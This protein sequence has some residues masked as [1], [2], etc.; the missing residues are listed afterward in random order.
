MTGPPPP[1]PDTYDLELRWRAL[2]P[3]AGDRLTAERVRDW[4]GGPVLVA[5]DAAGARHL[6]VRVDHDRAV[7]LPRPVAG[8]GLAVRRLHPAGQRDAA[9]ID[10]ACP[11]P[12]W[13][14]TFCG[15]CADVIAELPDDGPAEPATLLAVLER[16]RR[17]WANDRDGLSRDEQLGL[18]GELWLLLEWL[19][20][21]TVNN[22]TAW[23]GPLRGRHDFVTEAISVE[24]KTT[25]TATGPVVHR[26]ARLDQLD[27]PGAGQLYLLSLRAVPDPLGSD[28][29]DT[30]L[31]RSR[32]AAAAA[33]PTCTAL[34]DDRLRAVGVT[35]ADDG[36]YTEPL[37]VAQ[38][39]LYQVTPDFPRLV[40]SSF[41]RGLPAGV[42]D[43]AYSL[44]TSACAPWL[45][46]DSAA[47]QFLNDLG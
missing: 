30:L 17:F 42:V 27:E 13:H 12:A 1:P 14:R 15:L 29:L 34:L 46:A 22:L 32:A 19:P 9:W 11:D 24:V 6:L 31:L 43:V 35:P 37:R 7:R 16:W 23:Q 47:R 26:V 40:V 25:R 28:D 21:L 3:P 39:E 44:D 33:G 38:Q 10:L 20:R 5:L 18:L 41:P 4:A 2:T 45:V 36:R 8:L